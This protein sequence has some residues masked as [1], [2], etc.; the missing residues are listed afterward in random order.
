[1]SRMEVHAIDGGGQDQ[2]NEERVSDVCV[3][4]CGNIDH[5]AVS[6][7]LQTISNAIADGM[8]HIHLLFQSNGGSVADGVCLYNFFSTLPIALTVYNVG[9]IRSAGIMAYLGAKYRKSS[10][11]STFVL[12]RC[13]MQ[14]Q[15]GSAD[16]MKAMAES[17]LIEQSRIE[18][19]L[20]AHI[21]L[22]AEQ[23][24][25]FEQYELVLTPEKAVQA[26]LADEIAEFSPLPHARFYPLEAFG[27]V[28]SRF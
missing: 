25:D 6:Q 8:D 5:T 11:Y 19:I 18:A 23:W 22:T 26:H 9:T 3:A 15:S 21:D 4:F 2:F 28:E 16:Q 17:L 7:L 20:R 10:R 12:H 14:N 24:S 27:R 13:R 1:M